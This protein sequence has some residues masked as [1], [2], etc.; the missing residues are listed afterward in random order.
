MKVVEGNS[1]LKILFTINLMQ[2]CVPA[3][4]PNRQWD[5]VGLG[6]TGEARAQAQRNHAEN[7]SCSNESPNIS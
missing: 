2:C 4:Q 3:G 7:V 5:G 6:R 1:P